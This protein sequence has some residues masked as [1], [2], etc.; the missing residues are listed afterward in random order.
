MYKKM[1]YQRTEEKNVPVYVILYWLE[2]EGV[3]TRRPA[4]YAP[5]VIWAENFEQVKNYIGAYII[6][7]IN[8]ELL[9]CA[10]FN[11]PVHAYQKKWTAFDVNNIEEPNNEFA[12]TK[13]ECVV[14]FYRNK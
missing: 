1:D 5:K 14:A 2:D 13:L 11:Y 3:R 10:A 8:Y 12:A 7:P 4:P 6:K 9:K